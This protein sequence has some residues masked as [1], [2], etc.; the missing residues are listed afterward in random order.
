MSIPL[1]TQGLFEDYI[2]LSHR[3]PLFPNEALFRHVL[4]FMFTVS[5]L[6]SRMN[7]LLDDPLCLEE[8]N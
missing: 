2:F 3:I 1:W 4:R 6:C 7:V 5:N 8:I